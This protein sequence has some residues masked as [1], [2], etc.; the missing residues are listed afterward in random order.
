MTSLQLFSFNDQSVRVI[1]V[2]GDPWFI[3]QDVL[4]AIKSTTTVTAAKTVIEKE[5]GEEFVSNTPLQ[6]SG[7]TQDFIIFAEAA[8]TFL[9]SRS[10]TAMGKAFNRLL[11]SE[12][13]PTIRKTGKYEVNPQLAIATAMPQNYIEALEAHLQSEKEKLVL[14]AANQKLIEAN[15]SLQ[16]EVEVLEPKAIVYDAVMDSETWLDVREL[17]K[18]L[19]IPKYREKD[20][21]AFLCHKDVKILSKETMQPYSTWIGSGLA[22]LTPVTLPTGNI[23]H[24]PVFSWK[25]CEKIIN[26]LRGHGVIMSSHQIDLNLGFKVVKN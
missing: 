19:A 3:A 2:N 17:F 26:A 9:V 23:Y 1:S 12:I 7:G 22:K 14:T 11:H 10:R 20:F 8:I 24:K 4:T 13:L 18:C 5:L 15:Q 6:T 25:G 21:R 16:S